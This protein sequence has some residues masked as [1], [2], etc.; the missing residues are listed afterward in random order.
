MTLVEGYLE[1]DHSLLRTHE[2]AGAP[3]SYTRDHLGSVRE[4]VT[5]DGT[6]IASRLSYDPW[7]K[8]TESGS[9]RIEPSS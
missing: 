8:L 7:G 3:F 2:A 6:T 9:G 1:A 4:V 5:S